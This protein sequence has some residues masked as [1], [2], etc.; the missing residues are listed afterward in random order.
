MKEPLARVRTSTL[1]G[2]G[3]GQLGAQIFRDTPAVLLPIFMTTMLGV[4]AWLSGIV[5]LI[6]K[7]WLIACDPLVGAYS[8][9]QKRARGRTPFLLVGAIL[10]SL[11][12]LALFAITDYGDPRIAAA[13]ICLLFFIGST[14]FSIFS[15]PY[16]AIASELSLDPHERTRILV[17]RMLFTTVG[18]LIGVGVAQPL[19]FALGGGAYGWH[20]MAI[21]LA[22]IC[23]V[24]MLVP[25]ITLRRVAMLP[26]G[27]TPERFLAQLKPVLANTPYM[28]LLA[29]CFVQGIGQASG[30]T[31]LGFVFLYALQAIWL[32]PAFIVVMVVFSGISQ[33]IWLALSRRWGKPR[34]YVVSSV[35]WMAVTI[36]WFFAKPGS[37]VLVT[38][39]LFGPLAT[40]HILILLRA[41]IIGLTN[42]GFLLLSLSLLTDTVDYQRSRYGV[43]HEGVFSGLFSA[44]EKLAFA[45]GPLIAGVVLSVYGFTSSTGGAAT[46]SPR[47][48][49]G[50]LLLYSLV[51]AG[52]QALSLLIFSRFAIEKHEPAS[53]AA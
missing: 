36:S 51:P 10:T 11:S 17:Y 49:G 48:I 28:V 35:L 4:P 47:A 6:P 19:V 31:V 3:T 25:A 20:V 42:S 27:A 39:P 13:A 16:L 32:V 33:P 8:D 24:T 26:G 14:A 43:A 34:T 1:L 7:L 22:L 41:A 52:T 44:A 18:V 9:R 30:Y 2:Y 46:Q 21:S 5:I 15:V 29:T 45:I 23:L 38:L 37:D 50:I 12:F 40:Q 53:D